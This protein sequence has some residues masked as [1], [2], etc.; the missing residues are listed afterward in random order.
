MLDERLPD[1]DERERARA[2]LYSTFTRVARA[3]CLD[4]SPGIDA[5][6]I[7]RHG[8]VW[9]AAA[10]GGEDEEDQVLALGQRVLRRLPRSQR[11]VFWLYEVAQLS[12]V[13]VARSVGCTRQAAYSRLFRGRSRL[14]DEVQRAVA[15][16]PV[17]G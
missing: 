2:W 15:K 11:L 7:V 9:P 12:M 6:A 1:Q 3:R 14:L 5:E 10:E 13:D 8:I 4:R 16:D 17:H